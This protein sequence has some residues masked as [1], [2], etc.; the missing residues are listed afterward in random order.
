MMTAISKFGLTQLWQYDSP[1]ECIKRRRD[2]RFADLGI[3]DD[4]VVAS[5]LFDLLSRTLCV[6]LS[7]RYPYYS[8]LWFKSTE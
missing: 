8:P 6:V 5:L 1:I 4:R 7:A 3:Q 2:I